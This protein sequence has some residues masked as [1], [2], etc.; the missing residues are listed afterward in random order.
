MWSSKYQKCAILVTATLLVW[1][2]TGMGKADTEDDWRIYLPSIAKNSPHISIE[3]VL[4]PGDGFRVAYEMDVIV[5]VYPEYEVYPNREAKR[6]IARVEDH[7]T[8]LHPTT[9]HGPYDPVW[10]GTLCLTGLEPGRKLLTV[11][12][13][14]KAGQAVRAHRYVQY[15]IPDW[16][17]PCP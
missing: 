6:V 15:I 10:R 13:I 3:F 5:R 1:L 16:P 2:T 8:E 7:E 12:A 4:P 17:P 9:W 11:I 14:D